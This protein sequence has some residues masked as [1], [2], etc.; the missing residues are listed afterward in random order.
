VPQASRSIWRHA[1]ERVDVNDAGEVVG[2]SGTSAFG[3][4]GAE[5]FLYA[6]GKMVPVASL[7]DPNLHWLLVSAEAINN[8]GQIAGAAF[9]GGPDVHAVLLTPPP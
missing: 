8:P 6:N 4:G 2:W 9:T 3:A 1:I 7:V 5:P